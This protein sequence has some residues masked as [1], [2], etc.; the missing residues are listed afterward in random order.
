MQF[1]HLREEEQK[2]LDDWLNEH[3][4]KC[5]FGEGGAIG[6]KIT[7]K[8]TPTTIGV[9]TKAKCVCGAGKDITDYE[10]W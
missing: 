5:N 8:I 3:S 7:Y 10:S 1:N 4:Q 2:F 9:I 6:G